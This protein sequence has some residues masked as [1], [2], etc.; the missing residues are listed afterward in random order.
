MI[1]SN[2][3]LYFV[4]RVCVCVNI[5]GETEIHHRGGVFADDI[6]SVH[7]RVKL[8]IS[9][10]DNLGMTTKS[11]RVQAVKQAKHVR[12]YVNYQVR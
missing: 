9:V 4:T 3:V 10:I 1:M 11:R 5:D 7:W 12:A 2:D 8:I 6:D